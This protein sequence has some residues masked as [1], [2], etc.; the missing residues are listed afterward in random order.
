MRTIALQSVAGLLLSVCMAGLA[1]GMDTNFEKRLEADPHGMVEISN[2]AGTIEVQGWDRPEVEI[3]AE[4]GAGVDRIDTASD[5]GRIT[6]K[7]IVPNHSFRSASADLHVRVPRGS[8]VDISGVSADVTSSDVEGRQLLKTVSGNVKAD[9]FQQ[10]I[11]LKTVS[12]DVA[13]RGRKKDAG[14]AGIHVSTISGN[15]RI[16]R[17]GGDVELTTVSG[18]MSVRLDHPAHNVRVRSTSGAVGFEGRLAQGAYLDGESVSGDLTVRAKPEGP[19]EY[20]VNTFS[21]DII[22]CMGK[23]AERVSRYGPGR[24]LNGSVGASGGG[25]AKVRLKTMS[26]D[27][28]LCDRS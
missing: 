26:G 5:H 21:G 2:V 28:E 17:A 14:A 13:L 3:R 27:V 16:D 23:D 10:S 24:R 11:E 6:I 22:N 8:D 9:V 1:H 12:G 4:V 20:E 25:E 19:L 18:D 7:V 15:I